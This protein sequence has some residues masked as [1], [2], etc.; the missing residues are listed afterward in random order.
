MVLPLNYQETGFV[1]VNFFDL[2]TIKCNWL[3]HFQEVVKMG[4]FSQLL[5]FLKQLEMVLYNDTISVRTISQNKYAYG[6]RMVINRLNVQ[7]VNRS[8]RQNFSVT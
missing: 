1:F 4:V 5:N 2:Y 8:I 6:T 3:K 7:C